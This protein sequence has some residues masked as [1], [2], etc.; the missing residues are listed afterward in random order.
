V[1][2]HLKANSCT[3]TLQRL[4]KFA[5]R[6]SSCLECHQLDIRLISLL[7]R[8]Q[9]ACEI[10]TATPTIHSLSPR[11]WVCSA[12]DKCRWMEGGSHLIRIPII[13]SRRS[14][15]IPIPAHSKDSSGR[16]LNHNEQRRDGAHYSCFFLHSASKVKQ[17]KQQLREW[18]TIIPFLVMKWMPSRGKKCFRFM[19]RLVDEVVCWHWRI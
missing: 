18:L 4:L 9:S 17:P 19:S 16:F 11:Y 14:K 5:L 1:D 15:G 8:L 12:L 2:R 6:V 7:F 10:I 3:E 13:Q